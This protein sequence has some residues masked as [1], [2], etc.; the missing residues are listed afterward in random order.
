MPSLRPL[1]GVRAAEALAEQPLRHGGGRG[2]GVVLR[3]S[4]WRGP[5]S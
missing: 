5:R 2:F 3:L 4:P 1:L